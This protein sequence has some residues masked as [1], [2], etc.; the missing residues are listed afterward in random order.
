MFDQKYGLWG[1]KPKKLVRAS[2]G[3]SVEFLTKN[4]DFMEWN[5][6]IGSARVAKK[7]SNFWPKIG[8]FMTLTGKN[9][10]HVS[11]GKSV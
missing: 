10:V 9:S 5:E 7:V 3:K 6:K 4:T 8:F 11:G 1:A 2:D